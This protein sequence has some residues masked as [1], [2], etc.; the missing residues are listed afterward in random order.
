MSYN[1]LLKSFRALRALH[2]DITLQG[3]F[4]NGFAILSQTTPSTLRRLT[5]HYTARA[6]KSILFFFAF[7]ASAEMG[8]WFKGIWIVDAETTVEVSPM[9]SKSQVSIDGLIRMFD[10]GGWTVSGATI[11]VHH[12]DHDPFSF[13]YKLVQESENTAK[14]LRESEVIALVFRTQKGM[15]TLH[16]SS[17]GLPNPKSIECL[18]RV[19]T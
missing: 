14:V 19:G 18:K 8:P 9:W 2:S 13:E 1:M 10:G 4:A 6:V 5:S 15:C 17:E 11:E 12:A 16:Y 3:L 7:D